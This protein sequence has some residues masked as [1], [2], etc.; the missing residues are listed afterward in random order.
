MAFH[1]IICLSLVGSFVSFIIVIDIL[2]RFEIDFSSKYTGFCLYFYFIEFTIFHII[3]FW[4]FRSGIQSYVIK[5]EIDLS[6]RK[7]EVCIISSK[8]LSLDPLF[9]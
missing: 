5:K 3:F 6:I 9:C 7:T 4:S 1:L 2:F 8:I